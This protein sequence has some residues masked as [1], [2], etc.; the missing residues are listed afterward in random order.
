MIG[1]LDSPA[2]QPDGEPAFPCS[3]DNAGNH[4][5]YVCQ[6]VIA[7]SF[8]QRAWVN[9][10]RDL[11]PS[12]F[13]VLKERWTTI[14]TNEIEWRRYVAVYGNRPWPNPDHIQVAAATLRK[15]G[16]RKAVAAVTGSAKAAREFVAQFGLQA[17]LYVADNLD[18]LAEHVR[19]LNTFEKDNAAAGLLGS[20]WLG[21]STPFEQIGA[22]L[23]LRELFLNRIG[24]LPHG[25]QVAERLVTL[26]PSDSAY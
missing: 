4:S 7:N 10:H 12:E 24:G 14:V 18:R 25:A 8:P 26:A 17:C 5:G 1:A 15:S 22:G 6:S 21:V 13:W 9:A 19:A 20:S 3:L 23:K 11:D 2:S 16:I